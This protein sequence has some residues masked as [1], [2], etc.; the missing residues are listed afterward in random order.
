MISRNAVDAGCALRMRMY[1]MP[2]KKRAFT[3]HLFVR[4]TFLNSSMPCSNS[5]WL[6]FERPIK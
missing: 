4:S 6:Y 5:P 2:S 3:Y 1:E